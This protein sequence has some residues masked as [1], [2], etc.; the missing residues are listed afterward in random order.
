MLGIIVNH[1]GNTQ[2]AHSL[3]HNVNNY[4]EQHIDTDI[5]VFFE[6]VVRPWEIPR[7]A[8]MNVNEAWDFNGVVIATSITSAEKLLQLPGRKR[9][10]LYVWDLEWLRM[11]ERG[12]KYFASIYR[13]PRIELI[14]RSV[15]HAT[16]INDIWNRQPVGVVEDFNVEALLRQVQRHDKN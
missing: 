3:I 8:S 12:V 15:N 11:P 14:A 9:R 16:I 1:L 10:F 5:I 7:F 6:N 4:L 2:L 13:N